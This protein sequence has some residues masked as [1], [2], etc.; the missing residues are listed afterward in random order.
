MTD[1]SKDR[2]L[3][4]L[5]TT[6][7]ATGRLHSVGEEVEQRVDEALTEPPQWPAIRPEAF[8]G[9]A[10][11]VVRGIEPQT[12]ADPVG[13]LV[14]VLISAGNAIGATPHAVADGAR[15][16]ARL[17]AV[18]VGNTSRGRKGTGRANSNRVMERVDSDWAKERVVSGLSSGE[19]LIAELADPVTDDTGKVI[20]GS[21]DHRLMVVEPEFARV[22]KVANREGSILSAT[23]RQ[24][25]DSGDL[26]VMTRK[27]PLRA[28]NAHVSI[29][30]Q[31]TL[32]ELHR[33]LNAVETANGFAN[34]FLFVLVRRSQL[35]PSGGTLID[36]D[37]D[38]FARLIRTPVVNARRTGLVKRSPDAEVLWAE[39]YRELAE[40][41]LTGLLGAVTA[42]A[43]ANLLRLSL[44]Y[45]L[46][47][48]SSTIEVQHLT[49]A[50]AVWDYAAQ[51]A[52]Y[53]FGTSSG[54]EVVD[55]LLAG[56]NE[57]GASGLTASEQQ[58]LFG[59]HKDRNQLERA[60]LHLDRTGQAKTVK[61]A[62]G[63]RSVLR[64]Y[65]SPNAK[66]AKKAN[67]EP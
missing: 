35:L 66:Q 19:G 25:Y 44:I 29:Q 2:I 41:E 13:L 47:D 57:A 42:R 16:P 33:N 14:D 22:L 65:A 7:N 30:G 24:A 8:H 63:G 40:E 56:L 53:I 55:K 64:T 37:F 9:V 52:A 1:Q 62:T 34:R 61:E 49:A 38:R 59:R 67:E 17:N 58:A 10:G 18:V 45:A 39:M 36:A 12:E 43:E 46:L 26:R 6:T 3:A 27:D 48:Q 32:E 23:I 54:D 51:S 5:Q 21:K 15:H 11:E 28:T 60:R 31:I 50:R 20:S 4:R